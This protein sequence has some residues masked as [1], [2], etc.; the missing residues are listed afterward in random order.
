[1]IGLT[2]NTRARVTL[3][4]EVACTSNWFGD[5][6]VNQIH[7]QAKR[8]ALEKVNHTSIKVI[9]TPVVTMVLVDAKE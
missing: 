1:M 7:E 6:T 3:T 8:E 9:G 2:S 5:T 4:I